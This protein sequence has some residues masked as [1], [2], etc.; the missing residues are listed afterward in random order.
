MSGIESK[1]HSGKNL[2]EVI[3]L[4]LKLGLIAFGGPAAHIA[5]MEDEVVAKRKWISRQNFLDLIGA[6]NLIPGPSSNNRSF[7]L[8]LC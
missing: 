5:M 6:T 8:S 7:C 3:K 4:F 1:Q 2:T